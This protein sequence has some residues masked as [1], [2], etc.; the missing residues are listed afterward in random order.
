M[1]RSTTSFFL[2]LACLALLPNT[3]LALNLLSGPMQTHTTMHDVSFWLQVDEAAPLQIEYWHPED[4]ARRWLSPTVDA[5]AEFAYSAKIR[6]ST[7]IE[8]GETYHHRILAGDP[9]VELIPTFR[10]DSSKTGPIPLRFSSKPRWRFVPEAD[11]DSPHRIFDY[12][13]AMG[14]CAYINQPGTDREGG[15]PYGGE[16]QIFESIYEKQPDLM[17]WLG[18][19]V[20]YR[21]NEFESRT[22][23]LRR[24]THDR[25]LP[26]MQALL[27]QGVHYATWD[28]HDYGPNNI[29]RTYHLKQ[30][31]TE[32][33]QAMWGN[34]SAGLPEI[35]GIFTFANWGDANIYFLD[36]RTYQSPSETEPDGLGPPK[37]LLGREQVDWLI[38]HLAWTK[39]Q[40]LTDRASYPSRFNL[41]VIGSQALNA[42]GNPDGYRNFPEEYQ[43]LMNRIAAAG[44][45]SV[46]FLSGDVHFGEVNR[47]VHHYSGKRQ[48]FHEVTSSPLTAGSWAGHAT[49]P[50]RLDVFP[51][52]ADRAGQRNFVTLDF[53]GPLDDRRMEIRFWDSDGKLLNQK[54]DAPAGRP[55]DASILRA[56]DL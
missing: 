20:Y 32:I 9:P 26:H 13:I 46:V 54:P 50:A 44:I 22:G 19:T 3:I 45:K 49:N 14:S 35:P 6:L 18:D 7:G 43:Y 29:G 2:A 4:P 8:P 16:Y 17:L 25:Q 28:D 33:F 21:E 30:E 23:M 34:P 11:S 51:G 12:R 52:E 37:A 24:W 5:T 39:S 36:N 48:V 56:N 55:T 42:S 10:E 15:D 40:A 31:A 27:T 53:T 41:I 47:V 38:D 1:K